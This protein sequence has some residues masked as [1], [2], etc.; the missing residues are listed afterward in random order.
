MNEGPINPNND[1]VETTDS[2]EAVGVFRG[3]KNLFFIVMVLCLL[4]TQVAFW[5]VN[6]G[7][8]KAPEI[9]ELGLGTP[10]TDLAGADGAPAPA[11][12]A[13]SAPADANQAGQEK[14][15]SG[16]V[17]ARSVG[18]FDFAHLAHMIAMT[19]GILLATA[20]LYCLLISA[21]LTISLAGRLGGIN[22]V[23]RAVVLSLIVLVLLMLQRLLG[24]AVPGVIWTPEELVRWL[25]VKNDSTWNVLTFYLRFTFYWVVVLVL[26]FLAQIRSARWSR[27]ILR[28]LEIM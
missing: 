5:T 1:M 27:A 28:R 24:P 17:L 23:S 19:N 16:G 8:I 15:K 14:G 7:L 21:G 12:A 4:L 6:S 18:K 10:T 25:A 22:Q 11:P 2:L 26:L 9:S 13:A 20:I 3:W